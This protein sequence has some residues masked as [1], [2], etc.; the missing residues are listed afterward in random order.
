[1]LAALPT[2]FISVLKDPIICPCA[3]IPILVSEI[4]S[5][6]FTDDIAEQENQVVNSW[7]TST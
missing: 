4:K 7:L 1:M 3:N 5:F 6:Y 2:Y